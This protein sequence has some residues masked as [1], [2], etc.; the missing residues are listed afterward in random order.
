M[1]TSENYREVYEELVE[2]TDDFTSE[3]GVVKCTTKKASDIIREILSN[4]YNIIDYGI[5]DIEE[6]NGNVY[7]VI[8]NDLIDANIMESLKSL[9]EKI[10][11]KGSKWQVQSEKGRNLGTYDTKEKAKKRLGQVEFFKRNESI[12]D[13]FKL[14]HSLK[15]DIPTF[16]EWVNDQGL[17]PDVVEENPDLEEYFRQQYDITYNLKSPEDYDLSDADVPDDDFQHEEE[18]LGY[19]FVCY[20]EDD[21]SPGEQTGDAETLE[22]AIKMCKGYIDKYNYDN[23]EIFGPSD[24]TVAT[25]YEGQWNTYYNAD[26]NDMD[27]EEVE[28]INPNISLC[29]DNYTGKY[30]IVDNTN[31]EILA[32]GTTSLEKAKQMADDVKEYLSFDESL[33]EGA[34]SGIHQVSLKLN[35]LRELKKNPNYRE[36]PRWEQF[37]RVYDDIDEAIEDT[38]DYLL[39]LQQDR[40]WESLEEGYD[41]YEKYIK[42]AIIGAYGRKFY[43]AMVKARDYDDVWG[44]VEL[45]DDEDIQ[46]DIGNVVDWC[47]YKGQVPYYDVLGEIVNEFELDDDFNES[48]TEEDELKFSPNYDPAGTPIGRGTGLGEELDDEEPSLECLN[49]GCDTEWLGTQGDLEE[50]KC[51]ECGEYYYLTKDGRV[52]GEEAFRESLNSNKKLTEALINRDMDTIKQKDLENVPIGSVLKIKFN[53][54]PTN[55]WIDAYL[56]VSGDEWAVIDD[57]GKWDANYNLLDSNNLYWSLMNLDEM[58]EFEIDTAPKRKRDL[59]LTDAVLDFYYNNIEKKYNRFC[60]IYEKAFEKIPNLDFKGLIKY[61]YI[62]QS[63]SRSGLFSVGILGGDDKDSLFELHISSDDGSNYAVYY[64]D[65]SGI[66]RESTISGDMDKLLNS[67]NN[68]KVE[69]TSFTDEIFN[70]AYDK[71]SEAIKRA[72]FKLGESLTEAKNDTL[73]PA[74]WE[75]NELKPEVKEKLELIVDKFKERLKEDGV[76]IDVDDVIIVGS[77]ANYNYTDKSDIDLH[78]IAD[79]SIYKDKEDLA[80]VVYNAYRRL[81]NDKFDPMIYG[82]EVELYIEPKE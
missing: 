57:D 20:Y 48:L 24:D 56:K 61:P 4:Y 73:N 3:S 33:N 15:E 30:Y 28:E 6:V 21:D 59:N 16:W 68:K 77:N 12:D 47:Q 63:T 23:A 71:L 17:D 52:V 42:K 64:F 22:D 31:Q 7:M 76:D 75:N 1:I 35:L 55:T 78:L 82:H 5:S 10:V 18:S 19:H 79:L 13:D 41:K 49:C 74:I 70:D 54:R 39:D 66:T 60:N 43:N 29:K 44:A 32:G 38:E 8:Y 34:R 11:K 9:D 36:D 62:A 51:P 72:G 58:V 27:L 65:E 40:K 46:D 2:E 26:I 53:D 37:G 81:F 67:F 69:I 14:H 45:I 25:F 80:Q 50:F